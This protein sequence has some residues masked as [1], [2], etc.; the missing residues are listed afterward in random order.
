M[1]DA[2]SEQEFK[3]LLKQEQLD[4]VFRKNDSGR[5]Y[6]VTFMDHDRR[7]VFNGSRMGKEFSANVFNDLVNGGTV[8]P[9]KKKSHSADRSFGNGTVT[10]WRMAVR[11][12]RRQASSLWIP[13]RPSITRKKRS[14]V[15]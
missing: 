2:R 15:A 8:F 4:V 11:L 14:A 7:E 3:K 9:G 13:I 5:I 10:L 12:N 1:R 6:G